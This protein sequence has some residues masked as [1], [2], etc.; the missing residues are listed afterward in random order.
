[1]VLGLFRRK[2]KEETKLSKDVQDEGILGTCPVCN[3]IVKK[4][5]DYKTLTF[6]GQKY[7]FHKKCYRQLLKSAKNLA[8]GGFLNI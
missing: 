6:R 4:T 7:I 8:K 2:K 1:M 3:S 5:D